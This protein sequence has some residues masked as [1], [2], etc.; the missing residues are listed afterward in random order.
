PILL[1]TEYILQLWL[2]EPPEHT[3][4][5]VQ[6]CLIN[7]L[8]DCL[9]NPLM[10]GAQAT[11]NIKWYQIIVGSLVFLNLPISYLILKLGFEPHSV[12]MVS[13]VISLISL[14][15]RLYFLK[16]VMNFNVREYYFKVLSKVVILSCLSAA[17]IYIIKNYWFL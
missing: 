7:L 13:I 3:M 11:G 14:Q 16:K 1:N 6:L 9:S 17:M 12:Y 2:K 4:F 5:F 8:I 10:I 15:F